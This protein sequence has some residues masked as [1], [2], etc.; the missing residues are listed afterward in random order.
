MP[1]V[2]IVITFLILIASLFIYFLVFFSLSYFFYYIIIMQTLVIW[3]VHISLLLNL[4]HV[5]FIVQD[6]DEPYLDASLLYSRYFWP[7]CNMYNSFSFTP[8]DS[9]CWDDVIGEW[10]IREYKN[11]KNMLQ[12]LFVN[13][14]SVMEIH[15]EVY[16]IYFHFHFYS[17]ETINRICIRK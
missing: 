2:S 6:M 12:I 5:V 13:Y 14:L 11:I 8:K 3:H 17:L 1:V 4:N 7:Y 16:F 10:M 9:P 15:F